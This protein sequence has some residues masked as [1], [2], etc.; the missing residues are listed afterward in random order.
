MTELEAGLE[1]VLFAAGDAVPVERLAAAL[2]TSRGALLEA[3]D[4]LANLY[5]FENRGIMLLRLADKLQLCSRPLYAQAARRVTE[6]R[7]PPSLSPAALEVLT[8]IAYRQ[9]VTRA[10]IDQLRG[11][12]SGGTVSGLLEKELI[13]EAGRMDVPGRPILYR[14]TDAFLRTFSLKSLEELPALPA[15]EENE[16]LELT[17][18]D[19]AGREPE[20]NPSDGTE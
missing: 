7:R 5:D 3:A 9:P 1:A 2:E 4:A 8:I 15:L 12:D 6:S 10:F 17:A 20:S 13:E 14:T 18:Q 16:Q 11:V 19:G